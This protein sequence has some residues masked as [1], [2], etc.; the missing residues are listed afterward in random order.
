MVRP[1]DRKIAARAAISKFRLKHRRAC[2]I[3]GLNRFTWWYRARPDRNVM[4]RNRLRELSAQYPVYGQPMLHNILRKE[5]KTP[6][7]RKRTE[8]IYRQEGLSLRKKKTRKKLGQLRLA[9]PAATGR[10]QVWAMDFIFDRLSDGRVVK[11]MTMIDHCTREIPD[12]IVA[13]S[14]RGADVAATLERLRALG[15]K[16]KVLVVDN[17]PEFRSRAMFAWATRHDVRLHFIEPGKP[18]QN[19]YIE[20]LNGK[21]RAECLARNLFETTESAR[22]LINAWKREYEEHRPHSSLGGLTPSEFSQKLQAQKCA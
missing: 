19:A 10:D 17:G 21:F 18:T 22:L 12:L 1:A 13:G 9:L 7:N 11:T 16:P 20:S 15:R 8:R 6:L 14:I 2:R 4:L 5:W 3:F